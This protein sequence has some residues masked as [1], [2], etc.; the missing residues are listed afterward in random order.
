MALTIVLATYLVGSL[1]VCNRVAA[2]AVCSGLRVSV[3]DNENRR[4]VTAVEIAHEL[5]D[6]SARITG[7][8]LSEI[9]TEQLTNLLKSIDK[10]EEVSIIRTTQGLI[11]IDVRP[12]VPIARIFDGAKSYYINKA[13]KR[14]STNARYHCDVPVIEGHFPENDSTLDP[15]Q[16]M[17]LLDYIAATPKWNRLITMVRVDK[18]RD[19]ILVPSISGHVI[20]FGDNADYDSKFM[21]LEKMYSKVLPVKGW[22][23]YDTLSV[24]WG[25]QVVATKRIKPVVEG[26][27]IADDDP[28]DANVSTMLA[29]EG[30]APGQ[31]HLG[32]KAKDDKPIPGAQPVNTNKQE[33]TTTP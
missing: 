5:G 3:S 14:I 26:R 22:N 2:T 17:P 8:P 11:S 7:M 9:N 32:V 15:L 6:L 18:N 19:I 21:R 23:F 27:V 29:A 25:G 13:G 12:L 31:T 16:L 20:N 10:I 24:K 33:N 1:F 28:D 30:V 4:F